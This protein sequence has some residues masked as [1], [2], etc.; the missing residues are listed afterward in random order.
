MHLSTGAALGIYPAVSAYSISKFATIRLGAYVAAENDN[1]TTIT[2]HPGVIKTALIPESSPFRP[3]TEDEANLSG[4][5]AVWLATDEA[6]FLNGRYVNASWD[7]EDLVA[8]KD[9]IV[10]QNDL[11]LGLQ[12][13]FDVAQFAELRY[14]NTL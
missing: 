3:F 7:I 9:E 11:M 13:K 6:R 5:L 12:G 14:Q 2:I 1:I 8:K 10:S 4:G